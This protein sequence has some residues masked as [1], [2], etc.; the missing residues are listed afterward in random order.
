M[1]KLC[2]SRH[3]IAEVKQLAAILFLFFIFFRLLLSLCRRPYELDAFLFFE[4][5]IVNKFFL[6]HPLF[7]PSS[8]ELR[9][10]DFGWAVLQE[11]RLWHHGADIQDPYER[12]KR[13]RCVYGCKHVDLG[14]AVQHQALPY[15][16]KEKH[17]L[18]SFTKHGQGG[19][20]APAGRW[21]L[22]CIPTPSPLPCGCILSPRHRFNTLLAPTARSK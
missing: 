7:V 3:N 20:G 17:F 12:C 5:A 18:R 2:P 10:N 1:R 16:R 4:Y 11:L 9:L 14:G 19:D 8:G 13:W 21:Q 6:L 15:K 22:Y